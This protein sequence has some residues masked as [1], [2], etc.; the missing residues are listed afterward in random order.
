MQNWKT[1]KVKILIVTG[2]I[3][4]GGVSRVV[5]L[6]SQEWAKEHEVSISLF[7]DDDNLA[8]PI[9][10]NI[11]EKNIPFRG[12]TLVQIYKLYRLLKK[13]HYDKI[14]GFSENANYPLIIA[15]KLAGVNSK[16]TLSIH[17]NVQTFSNKVLKRI[18]KFYPWA[19][20]ILT[21]SD[22]VRKDVVKLN[23]PQNKV[24]TVA[25]PLDLEL[26]NSQT[27]EPSESNLPVNMINIVSLGRLHKHKGYDLLIEAFQKLIPQQNN[28]HL[29]IIGDGP[30]KS[31]LKKQIQDANLNQNIT[32]LGQHS[33][34]F[35]I[36]KN[37]DI[38]VLS[39]RLEGWGLALTE[40]MYLGIPSVAFDCVNNG[41]RE[42]INNHQNGLLAKC[43]DPEDLAEKI[44]SLCLNEKLRH[45]LGAAG[46]QR[47][48][49]F[50]VKKVAKDWLL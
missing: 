49:E 41:P 6:L 20:A 36:L 33:Q 5:S 22:A 28:L 15:A 47:A 35:Q 37:A 18:K 7:R 1:N 39:S 27:S 17:N 46:H 9:G 8:Y 40:A 45:R 14:I 50:D 10:G 29:T 13:N 48:Q 16:V 24:H 4:L 44:K 26:I 3:V 11:V 43:L 25:N 12:C 31:N 38:F 23:L 32:L 2:G 21:V 42:I 19:G 34:P 30:E